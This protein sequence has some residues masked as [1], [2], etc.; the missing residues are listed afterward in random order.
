MK[1]L[2][3]SVACAALAPFAFGQTAATTTTTTTTYTDG[4]G[5]ITEYV[6]G[7]TLVLKQTDG[8]RPYKVTKT[9]TYVTKSGKSLTEDDV[10]MR[11]KIGLPISI[12]YVKRDN[13]MI[14]ER[15]QVDD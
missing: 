2:L 13:D 6:P 3:L 8:A 4:T 11:I 7:Q 10:K 12:K 1:K 5:T 15:V 9:T 14:V